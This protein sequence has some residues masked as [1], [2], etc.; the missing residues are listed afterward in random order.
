MDLVTQMRVFVRVAE[1]QGFTAAA[2]QLGVSK[3]VV[4]KYVGE[5]EDRLGVRLFH[6]TTRSLSLTEHGAGYYERCTH[7]LAEIEE[8][9]AAIGAIDDEPRG[10]VRV[11][12]PVAFGLERVLPAFPELLARAP[13]L[14]VDLVLDDFSD[15]ASES[16]A[17]VAV[18][19]CDEEEGPPAEAQIL[20]DLPTVLVGAP[21]YVDATAAPTAPHDLAFHNCLTL[22][23]PLADTSWRLMGASGVQLVRVTGTFQSNSLEALRRAVMAGMGLAVLPLDL[24]A[25]DVKAGRLVRVLDGFQTADWVLIAARAS[26]DPPPAR[27]RAVLDLLTKAAAGL[28]A[29]ARGTVRTAA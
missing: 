26:N 18:R 27:V 15:V 28:A 8:A 3:S 29:P 24:V 4:S 21:A 1:A 9:E 2:R 25:E 13:K 5:L 19:L 20:A 7:I 14:N 10:T 17:D 22:A 16:M 6:R 11:L 12:L 23:R